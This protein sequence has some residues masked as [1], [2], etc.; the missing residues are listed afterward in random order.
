MLVM[1]GG[2]PPAPL[3]GLAP[4]DLPADWSPNPADERATHY[5]DG[6]AAR[7][8]GRGL[9]VSTVLDR[10]PSAAAGIIEYAKTHPDC[11]VALATHG[12]GGLTRMLLGST[13]DKVIRGAHGPVLVFR[14]A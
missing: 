10:H 8:R 13:S 11:L 12:R 3:P 4:A 5:L 9:T 7:V 6:V 1:A 14:P 2:P